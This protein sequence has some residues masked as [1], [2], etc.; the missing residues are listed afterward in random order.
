MSASLRRLLI[1]GLSL[2]PVACIKTPVQQGNVLDAAKV[3]A[4]AVGDTRFRV[5]TLL[6]T[7]V[8][9]DRLHPNRAVYVQSYEDEATG[10]LRN[11]R[12]V[13]IY[14]KSL[15]VARIIREMGDEGGDR[16][17]AEQ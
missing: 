9:E 5:E 13:V 8:L 4:I 17:R 1:A 16:G 10:T 15:R 6:G 12:V 11:R 2:L 14:D 3:S 7:P